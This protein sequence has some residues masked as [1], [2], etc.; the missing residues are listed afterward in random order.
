LRR[1][2]F[3]D[4][5]RL[6]RRQVLL[7]LIVMAAI[8]VLAVTTVATTQ[9]RPLLASLATTRVSNTVTRIVSEAVYEAIAKGELEYDGLVSFEKDAEGRILTDGGQIMIGGNDAYVAMCHSCWKAAIREQKNN[10]K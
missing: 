5:R 6:G 9:M 8:A 3:Y 2:F 1:G 10:G 7:A 4:R